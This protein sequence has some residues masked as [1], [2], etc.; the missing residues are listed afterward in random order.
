MLPLSIVLILMCTCILW[1]SF[2]TLCYYAAGKSKLTGR[3]GNQRDEDTEFQSL[4][5]Q[6][7]SQNKEYQPKA[8]ED[9]HISDV[10]KENEDL[11]MKVQE[12]SFSYIS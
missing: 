10:L 7:G 4:P 12:F 8:F 9:A 5:A 2:K 1:I 11:K 6:S 3:G